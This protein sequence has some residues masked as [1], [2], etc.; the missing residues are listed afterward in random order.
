MSHDTAFSLSRRTGHHVVWDAD[1][2][3]YRVLG[4]QVASDRPAAILEQCSRLGPAQRPHNENV[5]I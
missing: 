3:V 2:R 1:A 5:I 4:H